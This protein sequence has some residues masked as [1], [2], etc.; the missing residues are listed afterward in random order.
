MLSKQP[1]LL[2]CEDLPARFKRTVDKL[3]VLHPS[4]DEEIVKDMVGGPRLATHWTGSQGR[5]TCKHQAL[6]FPVQP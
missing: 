4:G 6:P 3:V 5:C 1:R 2:W